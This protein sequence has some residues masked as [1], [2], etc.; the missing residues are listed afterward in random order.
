M[1]YILPNCFDHPGQL[2]TGNV[3]DVN[4]RVVPH[5]AMPIAPAK[6]GCFYTDDNPSLCRSWIGHILN[7]QWFCEFPV[8][9]C[10]HSCTFR[11]A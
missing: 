3:R 9:R 1:A 11:M 6:S 8:K 10:S 4:I 2:M 5:P 7:N